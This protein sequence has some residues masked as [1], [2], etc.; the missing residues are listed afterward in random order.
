MERRLNMKEAIKRGLLILLFCI[1]FILSTT[2]FMSY[3]GY[4]NNIYGN[5]MPNIDLVL[6]ILFAI[7]G[8]IILII[9]TTLPKELFPTSRKKIIF[10][11][12]NIIEIEKK[13]K[14]IESEEYDDFIKTKYSSY[15]YLYKEHILL[16][17]IKSFSPDILKEIENEIKDFEQKT[18]IKNDGVSILY[19][20]CIVD[21]ISPKCLCNL[22][23]KALSTGYMGATNIITIPLIIETDEGKIIFSDLEYKSFREVI[24]FIQ[25]RNRIFQ[26]LLDINLIELK[27]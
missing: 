18:K 20:V 14:K 13:Y 10:K 27:K 4:I 22:N 11:K 21:K 6:G 12:E 7:L 9:Y 25:Q 26:Y 16:L 1:L 15:S 2:F 5:K 19:I 23:A 3:Q 8:I 17:N 24:S